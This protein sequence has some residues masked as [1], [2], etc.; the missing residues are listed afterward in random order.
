M[1]KTT[2][3]PNPNPKPRRAPRP[4][5]GPRQGQPSR[6]IPDRIK[7]Y[8][9]THGRCSHD[10]SDCQSKA[11]NHK[12]EATMQNKMG[13]STYGCLWRCGAIY[14]VSKNKCKNVQHKLLSIVALPHHNSLTVLKADS[15]ATGHYLREN[16]KS[17]LTNLHH[18][19]KNVPL[20]SLPNHQAI[21]PT[22]TCNLPL[23]L[24][25]Q[26]TKAYIYPALKS[27]SLLSIA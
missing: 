7:N 1:T 19:T 14:V 25:P 4:S 11:P 26:M 23:P 9:W 20:V 16:E 21:R 22:T 12:N 24:P 27:A 3:S 6:P 15:G 13:G 10:S 5:T 17:I 8:F 2:D 18:V